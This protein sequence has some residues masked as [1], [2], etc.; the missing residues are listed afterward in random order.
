MVAPADG[1][2]PGR[3]IGPVWGEGEGNS[4]I[5]S[6]DRRLVLLSLAEESL[7]ISIETGSAT[8]LEIRPDPMRWQR[9]GS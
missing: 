1:S 2:G 8:P 3:L 9:L 5:L 6:P 4:W 7:L